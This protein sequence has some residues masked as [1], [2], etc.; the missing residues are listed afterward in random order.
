[1]LITGRLKKIYVIGNIYDSML[2]LM[3]C[4]V[5]IEANLWPSNTMRTNEI[6]KVYRL[7]HCELNAVWKD[8]LDT[9]VN[10][11]EHLAHI[12]CFIRSTLSFEI[13]LLWN[14]I[15]S[16]VGDLNVARVQG[17]NKKGVDNISVNRYDRVLVAVLVGPFVEC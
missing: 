2:L 8:F 1:M 16:Y 17:K 12:W 11:C 9:C 4:R 15:N 13:P 5:S 7:K 10:D 6:R 3:Y 14:W